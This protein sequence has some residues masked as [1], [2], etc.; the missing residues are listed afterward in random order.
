M[1]VV[2]VVVVV[3]GGGDSQKR[4][5]QTENPQIAFESGKTELV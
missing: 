1:V 4:E 3:V 5:R 2:V